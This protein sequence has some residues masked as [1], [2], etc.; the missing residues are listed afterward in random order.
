MIS[1]KNILKPSK[2]SIIIKSN[3]IDLSKIQYSEKKKK[4]VKTALHDIRMSKI[5]KMTLKD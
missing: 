4:E 3:Q 1:E 2:C 5:T